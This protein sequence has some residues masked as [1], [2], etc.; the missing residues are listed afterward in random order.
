MWPSYKAVSIPVS[1]NSVVADIKIITIL[2][3]YVTKS[4]NDKGVGVNDNQLK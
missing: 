2:R 4:Y 3:S 1:F